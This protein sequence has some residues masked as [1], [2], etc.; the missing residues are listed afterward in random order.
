MAATI[1][2]RGQTYN[3]LQ[4][5]TDEPAAQDVASTKEAEGF[6][7]RVISESEELFTVYTYKAARKVKHARAPK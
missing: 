3:F 1:K 6:K 7:T 4:T 5:Y 2:Y